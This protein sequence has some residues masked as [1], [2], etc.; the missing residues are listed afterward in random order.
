MVF[1][2]NCAAQDQSQMSNFVKCSLNEGINTN[3]ITNA[4]VKT[5]IKEQ[6]D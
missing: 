6:V 2:I 1:G 3:T 5:R 4:T